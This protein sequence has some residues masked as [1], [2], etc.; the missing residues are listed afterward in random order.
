MKVLA[1]VF[2]VFVTVSAQAKI[3]RVNNNIGV[4][5]DFTTLQA[6]HDGANAGDTLYLEGSSNTYG[7]LNSSKKLYIVGPGY[8][9][10]QVP[11]TQAV[12]YSALVSN[13]TLNSGSDGTVLAGL[14][15][16]GNGLDV[17]VNNVS[18]RRNKFCS[19]NGNEPIYGAGTITLRYIGNGNTGVSNII[20]TQNYGV[21][22]SASYPSNSILITNN[23]L[24]GHGYYGGGDAADIQCISGGQNTIMLVQNNVIRR[25]RINIYGSTLTNNIMA[26]G[27]FN[28][29]NNLYSNNI[30]NATQFGTD[31]GN[32]ANIDPTTVFT[33]TGS[34]DQWFKLKTG[35]PAIGAGYGST[36]ANPID[37]GV[38]SGNTPYVIAGQ[39]NMPAI[40]SFSNQPVGSNTD[41]IKVTVKVKAAG[42]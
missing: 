12:V 41:P 26:N 36:Q 25:G 24:A 15:F 22:I 11:N 32:K 37:C 18:I 34:W 3:W 20:I 42:N 2:S 6:A 14:D 39:V 30:A 31:N 8:Y 1:F 38:F 9:L 17:W 19:S 7:S 33:Y 28:T 13:I 10:D 27:F 21:Q 4:A 29:N 5:A 16:N 40:Y 35:S 23:V